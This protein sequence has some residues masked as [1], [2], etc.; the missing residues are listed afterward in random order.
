[1]SGLPEL[2]DDPRVW[3]WY[4]GASAVI[5][6]TA[7]I[8]W[9]WRQPQASWPERFHGVLWNAIVQLFGFLLLF[10]QMTLL[11]RISASNLPG[12][13]VVLGVIYLPVF[14]YTVFCISGR[15]IEVLQRMSDR[16]IREIRVTWSGIQIKLGAGDDRQ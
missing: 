6:L 15:G 4:F 10:I 8:V 7:G 9:W 3:T 1:M 13:Q 5:S 14:F 16:G 12:T 2:T 11:A